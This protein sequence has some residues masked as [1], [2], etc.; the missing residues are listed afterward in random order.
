MWTYGA[1]KSD[2]LEGF[3]ELNIND[4]IYRVVDYLD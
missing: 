2:G 3:L 4:D 1:K